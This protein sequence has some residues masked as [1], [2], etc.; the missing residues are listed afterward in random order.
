MAHRSRSNKLDNVAY[1]STLRNKAKSLLS[2]H[3]LLPKE[4]IITSGICWISQ[5]SIFSIPTEDEEGCIDIDTILEGCAHVQI[6]SITASKW[7]MACEYNVILKGLD[8]I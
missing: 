5:L 7:Y 4:L 1:Y 2:I 6:M 8:N 3:F